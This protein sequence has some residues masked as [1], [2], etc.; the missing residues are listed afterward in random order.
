MEYCVLDEA[1]LLFDLGLIEQADAILTAV[2]D[3]DGR[4]QYAFFSA[5]MPPVLKEL[6]LSVLQVHA[7][8]C[9]FGQQR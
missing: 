1:D 7:D 2:R 6:A 8:G 3:T 9:V 5:T 4:C